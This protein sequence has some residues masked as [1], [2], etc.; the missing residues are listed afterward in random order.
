MRRRLC[1]S[2]L[3]GAALFAFGL[4]LA[5]LLSSCATAPKNRRE[6]EAAA[7]WIIWQFYG[8]TDTPPL[9]HWVEGKALNCTDPNNGRPGFYAPGIGCRGGATYTPWD[10]WVAWVGDETSIAETTMGHEF[11]HVVDLRE[12]RLDPHHLG[13]AWQ[14]GGLV[15]QAN[16]A[17]AAAGR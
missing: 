5:F 13:P 3:V 1:R 4:V 14:E 6:G 7:A 8:R 2:W 17:V 11:W 12:G 16:A 15:D 10:V 9:V